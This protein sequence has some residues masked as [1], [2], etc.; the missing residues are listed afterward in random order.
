MDNTSVR[1]FSWTLPQAD[2]LFLVITNTTE[3]LDGK[4]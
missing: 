3:K 1:M 4:Y 2:S